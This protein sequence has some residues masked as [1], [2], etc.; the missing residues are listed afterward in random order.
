MLLLPTGF[1]QAVTA[2]A[3]LL[4]DTLTPNVVGAYSVRQMRSGY[5][6][7]CLRVRRSSDNAE[8][9]IGF[10]G[11]GINAA[12]DTTALLAFCGAGSGYVTKW[13]DQSVAVQNVLQTIAAEQP[14]IVSAGSLKTLENATARPSIFYQNT[15]SLLQPSFNLGAVQAAASLS[16]ASLNAGSTGYQR[17][18]SYTASG[19]AQDY[20]NPSSAVFVVREN[21]YGA[22]LQLQWG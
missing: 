22:P 16:V 19:Q 12:L 5:A 11:S 7:A 14:M 3:P 13:Y 4:L 8:Q 15:G 10:A 6:G 2:A 18:V 20:D 9:D 17:L 1:F 21:A